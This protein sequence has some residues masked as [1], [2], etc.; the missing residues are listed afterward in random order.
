MIYN[1]L[2]II[3][4]FMLA[5][6]LLTLTLLVSLGS[7]KSAAVAASNLPVN[8]VVQATEHYKHNA[9][10]ISE[11]LPPIVDFGGASTNASV[12]GFE[13]WQARNS[14]QAA[15]VDADIRGTKKVIVLRVYFQ[16]YTNTSRYSQADVESMFGELDQLWRNT[17]YNTINITYEVSSLFQLPDNRS[18]YIDDLPTCELSP[19]LRPLGDLS[20]GGKYNKVLDD[21]IANS[22]TGLNWNNVDAVMVLMAETNMTEFHRGQGN[23]CT[24]AMGPGGKKKEVGCAIF[25]ENPSNSNRQVWGRWAHEIGHAFQEGGPQHPSNYNSDFELMDSNM[26][27]QTGV[28]EKQAHIAFPGWLPT[29][30]YAVIDRTQDGQLICLDP[31]EVDPANNP[32]PQAIKVKITDSLYY[33]I[34]ERRRIL[35]DEL[36]G[37]FPNGIPDVG[38]LIERVSEGAAKNDPWVEVRGNPNRDQLWHDGDIYNGG[39]DGVLMEVRFILPTEVLGR[40]GYCVTIRYNALAN[41][42]DV[43][44]YPW[45]SPPG[46]TWETTDIWIDSPVNGYGTYRYGMWNDLSGNSVP[47]G[48][49]DDPAVGMINRL[50]ARVRNVGTTPATDVVV[51][52]EVA[53]P[54]GVGIAGDNGWK[55]I[56]SVD[57]NSFPGLANIA[58]GAF[59]DVYVG[60]KPDVKLTPKQIAAKRF[61][62]HSCVRVKLNAVAGETALGNQDGERE[63]ENIGYFEATANSTKANSTKTDNSMY[64]D[65]IYLHNDDLVNPKFFYLSYKSD[66]PE[67]WDLDVNDGN[68][69]LELAPGEVRAISITIT[70]HG[71][72]VIGSIFGVDVS[73]SSLRLLTNDLNPNDRHPEF[74]VLGGARIETRV[75]QPTSMNLHAEKQEAFI[76]VEG[77]IDGITSFFDPEHPIK[78]MIQGVDT[79]HNPISDTTQLIEVNKDGRFSLL[80]SK[81]QAQIAEVIGYFAGTSELTSSSS[82]YQ[83]VFVPNPMID[84]TATVGLQPNVCAT[85]KSITIRSGTPVFY[86]Y[87]IENTGNLALMSYTLVDS[88]LGMILNKVPYTLTPGIAYFVTQSATLT[89]TQGITKTVINTATWTATNGLVSVSAIDVASIIISPVPTSLGEAD[90]PEAP[91]L[92]KQLYL[93]IVKR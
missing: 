7:A 29:S 70:P 2:K 41:Q 31:M 1:K 61:T 42:P 87:T 92:D 14:A 54:L 38:I 48:N 39:S 91:V 47:R 85:T 23:K 89:T 11:T 68:L 12:A 53:D 74:H 37:Y 51:N 28:F 60:W 20:C 66:L 57:K 64:Q 93:P 32:T 46:N 8:K 90:E 21:A 26:P 9:T 15:S 6:L 34:S 83:A 17:S 86:C 25:S 88:K 59:M 76:K 24:V 27:G 77:S 44:L 49:G 40:P 50:Y 73:A 84:L 5:A 67:I 82:D 43:M 52:W 3:I 10:S 16:D 80:L 22:P 19:T 4:V 18:T 35:G 56:G 58:P 72:A 55:A 62:L 36:N 79:N 78:I 65:A 45:T 69:G 71:P 13:Q 75:L 81:Q 33:L 30:K 63:Q